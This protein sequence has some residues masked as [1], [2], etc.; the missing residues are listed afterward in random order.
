MPHSTAGHPLTNPGQVILLSFPTLKTR[1][2]RLTMPTTAL[3]PPHRLK[4]SNLLGPQKRPPPPES[5]SNPDNDKGADTPRQR[6]YA[7]RCVSTYLFVNVGDCK[8]TKNKKQLTKNERRKEKLHPSPLAI[9]G[10]ETQMKP[11]LQANPEDGIHRLQHLC[12]PVWRQRFALPFH[13]ISAARCR[14]RL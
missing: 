2:W 1:M 10:A 4:P 12:R 6:P 13:E 7:S 3:C 11:G 14:G 8:S 9:H 5:V